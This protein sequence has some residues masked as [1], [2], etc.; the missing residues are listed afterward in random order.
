MNTYKQDV[1]EKSRELLW[2]HAVR[3]LTQGRVDSRVLHPA[4]LDNIWD[5]VKERFANHPYHDERDLDDD[6]YEDWKRYGEI[7]YGNRRPDELKVAFLC[8]P[9]PENDVNHLIRLGV[10]IENIY[11]FE[12]DKDCFKEAVDSLHFTYPNLKIF[13]GNIRDFLTLHEVKFDIIYLDFTGSLLSEFKVVFEILDS[14]VLSDLGVLMVHTTFPDK[15]EETIEFLT[16]FYYFSRFYEYTAIHGYDN[17]YIENAFDGRVV[18]GNGVYQYDFDDIR[19]LVEKNFECAYSA[20]Q[21]RIIIQYAN[22]IK[23]VVSALNNKL[24]QE[25]LFADKAEIDVML[26]DRKREADFLESHFEDDMPPISCMVEQMG[27]LNSGWKHFFEE[28][29][30]R[31]RSRVRCMKVVERYIV[32]KYE[33]QEDVLS[34]SLKEQLAEIDKYLIGGRSG[35]FCDVPMVHLWLE[36][37][38]HQF[39]HSYH[40]NTAQHKRYCYTAKTRKMCVDVFTFDKCRMLY[41]T[42][43]LV[44]YLGSEV[45]DVTRQMLIRMAVDA[46]DKHSVHMLDELY[47][48]SA[49]I[50][51]NEAQWSRNKLLPKRIEIV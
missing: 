2:N 5:F 38:L 4:Y 35:L 7:V 42:L 3:S 14:N 45:R 26:N 11:A 10:R 49:L 27:L 16:Q 15:T 48:G 46:I 34:T 9:E 32:A 51:I 33:N 36:I 8:G 19:N 47:Y 17:E 21:T 43:P 37:V 12:S 44:E 1:K 40:Q 25:R 41:D 39:G 18:E 6:K 31:N 30:N 22:L 29:P 24:L 28:E 20:F 13:R 50:G 23:P